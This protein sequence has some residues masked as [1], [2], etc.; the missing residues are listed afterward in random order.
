MLTAL[1][2]ML[3]VGTAGELRDPDLQ[4]QLQ[5]QQHDVMFPLHASGSV[6]LYVSHWPCISCL[7]VFSEFSAL[8]PDVK[9][10]VTWDGYA[11]HTEPHA[12]PEG[13]R[14][15]TSSTSTNKL[16][17]LLPAVTRSDDC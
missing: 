16:P 2:A 11:A 15:W 3:S 5:L 7:A 9:L 12:P 14:T 17:S 13:C 10:Q 8:F 6:H 1:S 4:Q